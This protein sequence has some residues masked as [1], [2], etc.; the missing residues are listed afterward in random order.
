MAGIKNAAVFPLPV[1]ARTTRCLSVRIQIQDQPPI[2]KER[3]TL[4][5]YLTEVYS[6]NMLA[7]GAAHGSSFCTDLTPV[8]DRAH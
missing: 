7:T 5:S 8:Q 4:F 3:K 1:G 6:L 2:P